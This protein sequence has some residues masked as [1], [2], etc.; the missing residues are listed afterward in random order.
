MKRRLRPALFAAAALLV[1]AVVLFVFAG[2][3]LLAVRAALSEFTAKNQAAGAILNGVEETLR[4]AQVYYAD[5][6]QIRRDAD[7]GILSLTTDTARLTAVSN[8][9]NRNVDARINSVRRCPVRI[10]ASALLTDAFLS[11]LGPQ[12]TFYVTLTGTSSTSFANTFDAAG[13]NQ[14]RHRIVLEVE[15]TAF[16]IF[17]GGVT[18]HTVRNE[19]CL[20]ENIIVGVTP[21][22]VAQITK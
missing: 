17:G 20:A 3:R 2:R 4:D 18:E 5:L 7:G 12:I 6:V 11:G 8:A 22:A 14:T 15:V 10:P 1:C 21:D 16:V 13:V 9:V 19:V